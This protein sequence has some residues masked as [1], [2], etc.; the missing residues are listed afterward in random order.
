MVNSSVQA[1]EVIGLKTGIVG[2]GL[3]G[4]SFARAYSATGHEVY[5]LEKNP[6]VFDAAVREQAV[7]EELTKENA[8]QCDLILICVYPQAAV[9]FLRDFGPCFGS[10]PL[11]IDCCGTKKR[12]TEAGMAAAKEFGFTFLGGHPMAGTQYSGFEHS[13]AD[14]FRDA[15]MV[16]VPPNPEDQALVKRARKLKGLPEVTVSA[17]QAAVNMAAYRE[18]QFDILAQTVRESLDMEKVYAILRGE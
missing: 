9:S 16:L 10:R 1:T 18:Q 11:V 17:E 6:Q 8:G 7:Q 4:G 5:A 12:M 3:I 13:R 15:P 2:L 14:L